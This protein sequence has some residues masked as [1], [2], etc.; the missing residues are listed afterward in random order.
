MQ[1]ET[2]SRGWKVVANALCL[3]TSG[4]IQHRN[5]NIS[6]HNIVIGFLLFDQYRQGEGGCSGIRACVAHTWDVLDVLRTVCWLKL[7]GQHSTHPSHQ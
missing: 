3:A 5:R 7:S 2:K 6:A 1:K 4:D